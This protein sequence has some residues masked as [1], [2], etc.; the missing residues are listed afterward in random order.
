M[1][2]NN[3]RFSTNKFWKENNISELIKEIVEPDNVD[4]SSLRFNE[5]L[6]PLIWENDEKLKTDVRKALLLNAKRFIEFSGLESLKFNDIVL[7]GSLANYNYN[8]NSDLDV[9]ILI[10][11]TQISDNV[12]FVGDY[13]KMKKQLWSDL[14]PIQVKGHDVELYFQDIN[15]PH[16][17]TGVYSLMKDEWVRKPIKQLVNIDIADIQLKASNI[18]NKI[19]DLETNKNKKD[20][21]EKHKALKD[22]IKK[23]RQSGLDEV[24]EYS[25]ENLVFKILRNTGYLKKMIDLK[26]DY[27]SKELN[28]RENL[29]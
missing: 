11:F 5:T 9:H 13:L 24:G 18:M 29:K 20:F 21:L 1:E 12:E 3:P 26:N 15:E 23:Y 10:D 4:V 19:D 25:I 17:S 2:Q 6:S 7:T 28:L 14:L 16:H 8:E 27:L 22:K